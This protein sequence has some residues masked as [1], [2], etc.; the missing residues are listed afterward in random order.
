M[1][2]WKKQ[3][4]KVVKKFLKRFF[5][6]SHPAVTKTNLDLTKRANRIFASMSLWIDTYFWLEEVVHYELVMLL[7][8]KKEEEKKMSEW[9]E[10]EILDRK[11]LWIAEI[12]IWFMPELLKWEKRKFDVDRAFSQSAEILRNLSLSLSFLF[13]NHFSIVSNNRGG[14]F[15]L[16]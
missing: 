3:Q 12:R 9:D 14:F 2:P 13:V 7:S 10:M 6:L 16:W 1:Q 4:K 11:A 8:A 5:N 15:K